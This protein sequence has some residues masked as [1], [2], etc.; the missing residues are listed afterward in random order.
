MLVCAH[1]QMSNFITV[2]QAVN[3]ELTPHAADMVELVG[4]RWLIYASSRRGLTFAFT[5]SLV[6]GSRADVTS[7]SSVLLSTDSWQ[8]ISGSLAPLSSPDS[9]LICSVC[10]VFFFFTASSLKKKKKT[11]TWKLRRWAIKPWWTGGN[12]CGL[13]TLSDLFPYT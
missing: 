8:E 4:R 7:L 13:I 12:I 1:V 9:H 11:T 2:L 6:S 5:R 10:W 3:T